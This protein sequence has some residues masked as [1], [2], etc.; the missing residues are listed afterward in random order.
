MSKYLSILDFWLILPHFS[1]FYLLCQFSLGNS[2][3]IFIY[4]Y[5]L[6]ILLFFLFNLGVVFFFHYAIFIV[7]G[8]DFIIKLYI[9]F[10]FVFHLFLGNSLLTAVY[11]Q[12]LAGSN[13]LLILNCFLTLFMIVLFVKVLL[14]YMFDSLPRLE[15]SFLMCYIEL[16]SSFP[17]LLISFTQQQ[18]FFFL[19]FSWVSPLDKLCLNTAGFVS[20]PYFIYSPKNPDCPMCTKQ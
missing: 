9:I 3:S 18:L 6:Y 10:Y 4:Q 16:S 13:Y 11:H 12:Y 17:V 5:K 8:L 2:V 7:G 15:L 20:R 1:L 14:F 19:Q